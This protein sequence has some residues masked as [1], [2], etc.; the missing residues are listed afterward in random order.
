[1]PHH[2]FALTLLLPLA[3]LAASKAARPPP[4][5]EKHPVVDSYHGESITDPYQ[6]LESSSDDKV[7]AWTTGQ[8]A[9]TRAVL[10]KLPSRAP[11][12]ERLT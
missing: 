7:K 5:A 9:Y 6:W 4:P 12:R 10:D 1:M 8:N 2:L 11:I 3:T